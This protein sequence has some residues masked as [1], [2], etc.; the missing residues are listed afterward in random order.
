MSKDWL[1]IRGKS[2]DRLPRD[3][4]IL[5]IIYCRL[6]D[7]NNIRKT[8]IY[9]RLFKSAFPVIIVVDSKIVSHA[10]VFYG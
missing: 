4:E 6:Q 7:R 3:R 2:R 9:I 1:V 10:P 8:R 5:H